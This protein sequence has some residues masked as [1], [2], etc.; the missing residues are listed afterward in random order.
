MRN[1]SNGAKKKC[2]ME[3]KNAHLCKRTHSG[4]K[5][6]AM[7]LYYKKRTLVPKN[8]HW[9]ERTP[10]PHPSVKEYAPVR[11]NAHQCQRTRTSAK[12]L[13]LVQKNTMWE[14]RTW[15][16]NN[17][18]LTLSCLSGLGMREKLIFFYFLSIIDKKFHLASKNQFCAELQKS[19]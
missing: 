16:C 12:E 9:C 1:M 17:A 5:K 14:L 13:E 4:V 19:Q 7:C 6:C 10:L 2:T 3:R 11:K 15:S 18:N 8:A